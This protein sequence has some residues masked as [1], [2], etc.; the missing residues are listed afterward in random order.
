MFD[1]IEF[2]LEHLSNKQIENIERL[3]DYYIVECDD[4]GFRKWYNNEVIGT[5]M[6]CGQ[7]KLDQMIVD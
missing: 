6:H 3:R 1:S 2:V 4:T 5:C 7:K